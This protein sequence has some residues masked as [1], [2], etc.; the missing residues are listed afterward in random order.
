MQEGKKEGRTDILN[1]RKEDRKVRA[2]G[3]SWHPMVN[4]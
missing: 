4:L 2:V 3:L 1:A